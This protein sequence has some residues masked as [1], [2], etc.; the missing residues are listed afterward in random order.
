MTARRLFFFRIRA[1]AVA[2]QPSAGYEATLEAGLDSDVMTAATNGQVLSEW[3]TTELYAPLFVVLAARGYKKTNITSLP[4]LS[5]MSFNRVGLLI[6]DTVTESEGAAI[7]LLVG[8]IAECPVQRHIGRVKDGALSV[9]KVYIDD[10]D[11]SIA[12]VETLHDKGY[13]TFRCFTGKG[14]YYFTD[15]C[16]ACAISD[17]YRSIA[18]RRTI[19]KA[20]RIAYITMLENVND[21]IPITNEG[22]LVPSVVKSWE[23]EMVA[24]IVNQMTAQGELGADPDNSADNGVQCYINPEQQ[25]ASTSRIAVQLKVKPYGYS[26]YIDVEL[27][28]TTINSE[29]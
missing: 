20:Y 29:D 14:G 8:R 15:D 1:L 25:I 16:L 26:K 21:E 4:D 7:G 2:Y 17:D 12:D 24:A 6:G 5:T 11:P 19:D 22:Y 10:E 23:A 18:R 3:A 9:S 28:F 27:G 13:I